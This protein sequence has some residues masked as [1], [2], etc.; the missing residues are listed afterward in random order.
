MGCSLCDWVRSKR[1]LSGYGWVVADTNTANK[2]WRATMNNDVMDKYNMIV[3]GIV[4]AL[5][6]AKK[7][8]NVTYIK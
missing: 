2:E 1:Q 5:S 8:L 7:R 6:Y 4:A 3:G